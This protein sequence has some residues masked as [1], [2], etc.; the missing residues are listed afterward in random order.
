MNKRCDI[1][2]KHLKNTLQREKRAKNKLNDLK[3]VINGAYT[4][5]KDE[6]KA[7]AATEALLTQVC[8]NAEHG[9]QQVQQFQQQV[10]TLKEQIAQESEM[11]ARQAMELESQR[12]LVLNFKEHHAATHCK[13]DALCK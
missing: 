1:L 5:L 7:R 9:A 6:C 3:D 12:N 4:R 13:H 10:L 2:Y 11:L 8:N